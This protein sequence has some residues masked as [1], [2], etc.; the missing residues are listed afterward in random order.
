M[1]LKYLALIL[2]FVATWLIV[3]Q[4]GIPQLIKSFKA[5]GQ[6]WRR[7]YERH[8][9]GLA[10][11]QGR[12]QELAR[13]KS[14]SL[15]GAGA[16]FLLGLLLSKL[17]WTEPKTYGLSLLLS[18]LG[19]ATPGLWV[20]WLKKQRLKKLE[21]QL[22]DMLEMMMG[23]MKAGL[24]LLQALESTA[25]E[26]AMPM[27]GELQRVIRDC[28]LGV[29]PEEALE[30]M[31]VRWPNPDWELFVIASGVSLRTGAN[32]PAVTERLIAT[33]RERFRLRTRVETLT[34]QGRL[35]GWVVG[36]LPVFLTLALTLFE[37][38]LMMPF[39]KHPL[40]L[41]LLGVCLVLEVLGAYFINKV[42]TI[43]P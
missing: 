8:L 12:Q 33:I 39:F 30:K 37:P 31:L 29:A 32:L 34:A 4:L 23:A 3:Q 14:L 5:L 41:G 28:R 26:A 10:L 13:L 27:A 9:A 18:V 20:R 35:S 15:M 6:A 7:Y 21:L 22:P 17:Q 38:E 19:L 36:L 11:D 40:G 1:I 42:A 24:S 2:V 16:G 25:Q 43:R